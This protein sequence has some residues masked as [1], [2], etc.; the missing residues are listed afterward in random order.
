MALA[1]ALT[2]TI[3][4]KVKATVC[5]PPCRPGCDSCCTSCDGS[6]DN[7]FEISQLPYVYSTPSNS[8]KDSMHNVTIS[9]LPFSVDGV[10]YNTI[11]ADV[12]HN[13]CIEQMHCRSRSC[14]YEITFW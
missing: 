8:C 10:S 4:S 6:S 12:R 5:D 7:D 2:F 14:N 9:Q 13:Y 11:P 3:V 1:M